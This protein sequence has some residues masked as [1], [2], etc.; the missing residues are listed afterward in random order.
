MNVLYNYKIGTLSK[1]RNDAIK[2]KTQ[3][4]SV[5][6]VELVYVDVG[7]GPNYHTGPNR[8]GL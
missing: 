5:K 6:D 4:H 1:P 8:G 3:L 2:R 7:G